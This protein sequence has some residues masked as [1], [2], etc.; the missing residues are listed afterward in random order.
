MLKFKVNGK[1]YRLEEAGPWLNNRP[2]CDGCAGETD[3]KLCF[4]LP[5]CW[6]YPKKIFV[7]VRYVRATNDK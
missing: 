7:E 4:E 2:N 6:L 3:K 5:P 1:E